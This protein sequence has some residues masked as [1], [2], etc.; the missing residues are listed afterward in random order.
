[1]HDLEAGGLPPDVANNIRTNPA[2][3]ALL[4]GRLAPKGIIMYIEG[5]PFW[6]GPMP[7]HAV[8]RV[9]DASAPRVTLLVSKRAG[10]EAPP[11]YN[12]GDAAI[13]LNPAAR[14]ALPARALLQAAEASLAALEG[15][16][17]VV[18]AICLLPYS[19]LRCGLSWNAGA[20]H[21]A[22]LLGNEAARANNPLRHV[23]A[24]APWYMQ[25]GYLLR[26]AI[27][28]ALSKPSRGSLTEFL[29]SRLKSPLT[30]EFMRMWVKCKIFMEC[31]HVPWTWA[32]A[33]A[34]TA[35]TLFKLGYP[36][37]Q[38]H[39][40]KPLYDV[41]F[42]AS[43]KRCKDAW[44]PE[45]PCEV[46]GHLTPSSEVYAHVLSAEKCNNRFHQPDDLQQACKWLMNQYLTWLIVGA[47]V[48]AL[49]ILTLMYRRTV[50]QQRDLYLSLKHEMILEAQRVTKWFNESERH[51][52]G[53]E[54]RAGGAEDRAGGADDRAGGADGNAGGADGNDGGADDAVQAASGR[55]GAAL[56]LDVSEWLATHRQGGMLG[57]PNSEGRAER[58]MA[59]QWAQRRARSSGTPLEGSE[60]QRRLIASVVEIW[61][62]T[63]TVGDPNEAALRACYAAATGT[64]LPNGSAS[65]AAALLV[66]QARQ[67][68]EQAGNVQGANLVV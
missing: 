32:L 55:A 36:P 60:A 68:D 47:S 50:T 8:M 3:M 64:V 53:A 10:Q 51:D 24:K 5:N 57:H 40:S 59:A 27:T 58:L 26:K 1:M 11:D 29:R 41:V 9:L 31:G 62:A 12:T 19:A 37:L 38:K 35:G 14:F 28:G 13:Y 18:A 4:A 17:V 33:L 44:G 42:K 23:E 67:E 46:D 56:R 63:A 2:A 65:A 39:M 34:A 43:V 61:D 49:I 16:V 21:E 6:I 15:G 7:P 45:R 66:L 52:A 25:D 48:M 54:D 30:T 22:P 20:G